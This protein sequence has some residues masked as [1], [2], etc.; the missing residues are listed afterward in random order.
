M[1][2]YSPI[3]RKYLS[4]S[5]RKE[6]D[7]ALFDIIVLEPGSCNGTVAGTLVVKEYTTF[8]MALFQLNDRVGMLH[9]DKEEIAKR[10]LQFK[11]RIDRKSLD[12]EIDS[13]KSIKIYNI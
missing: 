11:K 7:L 9:S 13:N 12:K 10:A 8:D 6:L 3:F 5:G 4:E 2:A 1:S